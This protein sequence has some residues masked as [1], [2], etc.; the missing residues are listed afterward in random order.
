MFAASTIW[1]WFCN[2]VK[3]SRDESLANLSL[4]AREDLLKALQDR[5]TIKITFPDKT[6]LEGKIITIEL[7]GITFEYE[8]LQ[9]NACAS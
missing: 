1:P 4:W 9:T 3:E 5:S 2:Q 6:I 8:L 7:S